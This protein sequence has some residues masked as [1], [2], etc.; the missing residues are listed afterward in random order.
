MPFAIKP[1]QTV[2]FIGDSI[3]DCGRRGG[4]S[5]PLG[6]GYVRMASELIVAKY[7]AHRLNLL[8]RGISGNTVRDLHD[9]WSDDVIAHKPDWLSIK[10]GINDLHRWHNNVAGA[11]VSPKEFAELYDAIL[12]RVKKE[13]RAN[14]VLVDPFYLST[15][16]Y[17]GTPRAIIMEKLP[18]YIKTVHKMVKKYKTRHV[19]THEVYQKILKHHN[20]E[21]LCPEPVHPYASGHIVIAHEWLKTVGW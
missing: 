2:L 20:P 1:T 16:T 5:A 10:I 11:S 6:D 13:T 17:P 4:A 3:T 14:V 15:D 7:P 18:L 8:N 19:K 12:A 21:S 9:R